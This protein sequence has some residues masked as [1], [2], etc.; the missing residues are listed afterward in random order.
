WVRTII[1]MILAA[2]ASVSSA[3]ALLIWPTLR[4]RMALNSESKERQIAG[5]MF[6]IALMTCS[7]WVFCRDLTIA[8][9]DRLRLPLR[10]LLTKPKV[11]VHGFFGLV[12]SP[13]V[14]WAPHNSR[15]ALAW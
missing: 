2:A 14:Y 7:A 12:G 15:L 6:V 10:E 9:D 3:Q 1:A 4:V 8:S 11:V 5:S 13:L